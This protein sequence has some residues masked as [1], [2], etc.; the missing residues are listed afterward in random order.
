[1]K[2]ISILLL[3]L[4]GSIAL[5]CQIR[6]FGYD[7]AGNRISRTIPGFKS[8]ASGEEEIAPPKTYSEKLGDFEIKLYP[9]PVNLHLTVEITGLESGQEVKIKV[10]DFAGKLLNSAEI[11][12]GLI[13]LDF[14]AYPSGLYVI[15]INTGGEST[16]WKVVKE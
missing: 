13:Q 10:Y 11:Y 3:L 9:N 15:R 8:T 1:M 7:A 12:T 6:N 14:S 16:E 2:R 5:Y 4:T